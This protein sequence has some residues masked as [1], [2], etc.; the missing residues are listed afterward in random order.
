MDLIDLFRAEAS[1]AQPDGIDADVSVQTNYDWIR[2]NRFQGTSGWK[3]TTI[4]LK[5]YVGE[6]I[7]IRFFMMFGTI[8]QKVKCDKIVGVTVDCYYVDQTI[9]SQWAIQQIQLVPNISDIQ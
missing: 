1:T 5:D 4:S 9:D 7:S 6:T 3:Q 2:L 8:E